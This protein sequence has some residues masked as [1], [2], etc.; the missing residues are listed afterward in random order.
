MNPDIRIS[1]GYR[2]HP[3]IRKLRKILGGDGIAS[4][5]FL[6]C[7][8]GKYAFDG[9]L[10]D[11][12]VADI[13]EAASW[14]GEPGLFVHTC[15]DLRLLDNDPECYS[16]HNWPK[17]NKWAATFPIRSAIARKN[18]AKRWEERDRRVKKT[19]GKQKHS[20]SRIT[21]GNT[22]SNTP[23]PTPSLKGSGGGWHPYT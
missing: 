2:D 18:I 9:K 10:K 20:I 4:H 22:D 8:A 7:E 15:V 12:D 13:E 6:L 19:Q 1:T 21:D 5:I 16:I 23:S 14:R 3:K 17:W 11:M